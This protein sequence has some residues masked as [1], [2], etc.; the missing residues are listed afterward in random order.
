MVFFPYYHQW[1]ACPQALLF[2]CPPTILLQFTRAIISARNWALLSAFLRSLFSTAFSRALLFA[3][4]QALL[5]A[6]QRVILFARPL[7]DADASSLCALSRSGGIG[8]VFCRCDKS[9]PSDAASPQTHALL[10]RA[11]ATPR[12]Y[13]IGPSIECNC[14]DLLYFAFTIMHSL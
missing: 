6:F 10:S 14:N 3:F 8:R 4:P 12:N 7:A 11:S 1:T 5:F 13:R 9:S 2:V